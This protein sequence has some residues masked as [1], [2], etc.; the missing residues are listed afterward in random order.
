MENR[1]STDP[2]DIVKQSAMNDAV[3]IMT[4]VSGQFQATYPGSD[5]ATYLHELGRW[6]TDVGVVEDG[7]DGAVVSIDGRRI[8]IRFGPVS[9]HR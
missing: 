5:R 3:S 7:P 2:R 4:L 6:L 8:A 1:H 9:G